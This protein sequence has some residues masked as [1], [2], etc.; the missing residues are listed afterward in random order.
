M[1]GYQT[2]MNVNALRRKELS[3]I[4]TVLTILETSQK[5]FSVN[6]L[7]SRPIYWESRVLGVCNGNAE[8]DIAGRAKKI[9]DRLAVISQQSERDGL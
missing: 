4:E 9:L 5:A 3:H 7:L 8:A 1:A 6:C 2:N